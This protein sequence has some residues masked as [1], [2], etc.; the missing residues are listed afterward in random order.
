M[1]SFLTPGYWLL[2]FHW[3]VLFL[4]AP[5]VLKMQSLIKKSL[6]VFSEQL[7]NNISW[8]FKVNFALICYLNV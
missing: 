5:F 2:L 6:F 4:A 7:Q 3:L 1:F 8:P